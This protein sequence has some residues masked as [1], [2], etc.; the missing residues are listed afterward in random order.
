MALKLGATLRTSAEFWL[1][2]ESAVDLH[3]AGSFL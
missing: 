3:R 1:N 2:A